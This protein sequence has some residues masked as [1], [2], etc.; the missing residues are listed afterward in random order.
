MDDGSPDLCGAICDEYAKKDP[1]IIVIHQ[2]NAGVSAA[3]NKGLDRASGEYITFCDP[4]DFWQPDWLQ[5]LYTTLISQNADVVNGGFSM[6]DEAGTL[7]Q[8]RPFQENLSLLS[9]EAALSDYLISGILTHKYGWEVWTRLFKNDIIRK[10]K[11]RFCEYNFA[12]DLF[13][14]LEYLLY[15]KRTYTGEYCGYHYTVRPGSI[16]RNSE[17]VLR[18]NA[19]SEMSKQLHSRFQKTNPRLCQRI[20]PVIYF[21]V[22]YNQYMKVIGTPSY[23]NLPIELK[24]IEDRK[25]F[26]KQTRRIKYSYS[27]FKSRYGA[28]HAQRICFFSHFC[29]HQNWKRFCIESAIFYRWFY[30]VR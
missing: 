9:T 30:K 18:L 29:L 1:R 16:M 27:L 14:V 25:W 7:I 19:M 28:H 12:E 13:F 23:Q 11:I 8:Q 5:W 24:K 20:F 6:V 10:H 22:M 2:E 21:S 15:T 4:D 26:R 17:S 3:R